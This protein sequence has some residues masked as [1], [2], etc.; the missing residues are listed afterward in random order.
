[1]RPNA[2]YDQPFPH[3]VVGVDVKISSAAGAVEVLGVAVNSPAERA[4][5]R[6]GDIIARIDGHVAMP[7]ALARVKEGD[8]VE[9]ERKDGSKVRIDAARFY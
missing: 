9:L 4:G 2:S 5:L 1:M 3:R 6:Q 8:T 7:D